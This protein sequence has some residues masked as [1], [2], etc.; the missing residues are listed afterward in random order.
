MLPQVGAGGGTPSPKNDSE[1][2]ARM[3][4]PNIEVA[5]PVSGATQLGSTW[6][7]MV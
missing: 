1:L 5:S 2:S 4:Q 6:R 7:A 3:T